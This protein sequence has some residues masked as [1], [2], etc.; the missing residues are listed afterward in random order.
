[1]TMGRAQGWLT[2]MLILGKYL[3]YVLSCLPI[4][5]KLYFLHLYSD[6]GI[7]VGGLR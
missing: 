4:V 6:K 5:N 3:N 7:I 1:M 2:N